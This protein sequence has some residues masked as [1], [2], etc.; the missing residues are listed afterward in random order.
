MR[1]LQSQP[2]MVCRDGDKVTLA[3]S[4]WCSRSRR[5][6]EAD[7]STP[8]AVANVLL[9]TWRKLSDNPL[10]YVE[11]I[12]RRALMSPSIVHCQFFELFGGR[13]LIASKLA[14]LW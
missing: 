13:Q 4:P 3:L 10:P 7:I 5:I 9:S 12:D 11:G 1:P 8:V 2:S 14:S 6:D